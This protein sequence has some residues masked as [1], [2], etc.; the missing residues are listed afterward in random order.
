[1]V[2]DPGIGMDDGDSAIDDP[3]ARLT[4]DEL[5]LTAAARSAASLSAQLIS[6][7]MVTDGDEATPG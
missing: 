7:S 4:G 6:F 2:R 1:M 5:T 3:E